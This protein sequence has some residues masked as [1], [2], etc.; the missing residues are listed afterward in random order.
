MP[1]DSDAA[2]AFDSAMASLNALHVKTSAPRE[3]YLLD[4]GTA[5]SVVDSYRYPDHHDPSFITPGTVS[6]RCNAFSVSWLVVLFKILSKLEL[7]TSDVVVQL[8]AGDGRWMIETAKKTGCNVVAYDTD[9]ELEYRCD[10][11]SHEQE[12][13]DRV[14]YNVVEDVL[15]AELEEATCVFCTATQENMGRLREKLEAELDP[16]A[17]VVLVGG[18][19]I[20]WLHQHKEKHRGVP[21]YIYDRRTDG[22]LGAHD[23]GKYREEGEYRN[24]YVQTQR[25][26][27]RAC[28]TEQGG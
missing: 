26:H 19:M 5:E 13:S 9:A 7:R 23:K 18:E 4:T 20:G 25:A 24:P 21:V 28:A 16:R 14:T 27:V 22:Y 10:A 12:V 2:S 17:P 8:G 6:L 1:S 15:D 11:M 3:T